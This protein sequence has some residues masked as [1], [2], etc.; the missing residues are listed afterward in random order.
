MPIDY[1]PIFSGQF[2]SWNQEKRFGVIVAKDPKIG[3]VFAHISGKIGKYQINSMSGK[4]CLFA[5]GLDPHFYLKGNEVI[6]ALL[7]ILED[8]VGDFGEYIQAREHHLADSGNLKDFIRAEWYFH[9][10][11]TKAKC[12]PRS[13]LD[14][15]LDK[16]LQRAIE[17]KESSIDSAIG[18]Q[19]WLTQ[20]MYSPYFAINEEESNFILQNGWNTAPKD[21][22]EFFRGFSLADF[23]QLCQKQI[24]T[25]DDISDTL[26]PDLF[27]ANSLAIDIESN[28]REIYQLGYATTTEQILFDCSKNDFLSEIK[29]TDI[30][31]KGKTHWLVGHNIIAW[32][33]PVLKGKKGNYFSTKIV[34]DTLLLSWILA[35]WERTHAIVNKEKAHKADSDAKASL[36]LFYRQI[37]QFPTEYVLELTEK[38]LEPIEFFLGILAFCLIPARTVTILKS[39]I[40]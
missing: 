22:N 11:S 16:Q 30:A 5:L 37:N 10:W 28:G 34:W 9:Y 1:R 8:D 3:N 24:I 31:A 26:L 23:S 18:L 39:P 32:D 25:T 20:K 7:W 4:R 6:S 35:P 2:R 13:K 19:K 27:K 38:V 29:E 36:D 14:L 40:I 17:K 21:S 12:N 15:A 33:L